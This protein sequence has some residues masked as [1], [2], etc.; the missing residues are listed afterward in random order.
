MTRAWRR[1]FAPF[2]LLM[3]QGCQ[4]VTGPCESCSLS[5]QR[6]LAIEGTVNAPGSVSTPR[7][8]ELAASAAARAASAP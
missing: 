5:V 4:I 3:L 6:E 8:G 7:L 2:G 1:A